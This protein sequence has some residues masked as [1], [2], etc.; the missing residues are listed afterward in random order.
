MLRHS[1]GDRVTDKLWGAEAGYGEINGLAIPGALGGGFT[2]DVLNADDG[3]L[4][5]LPEVP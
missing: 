5:P 4:L 1:A 2:P 3:V